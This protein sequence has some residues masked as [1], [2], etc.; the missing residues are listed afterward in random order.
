MKYAE[1]ADLYEELE[2]TSKNL[3]KT[4]LIAEFLKKVDEKNIKL[5]MLLLQG[6]VFPKHSEKEVGVANNLVVKLLK[7]VSGKEEKE[8]KKV[9]NETGDL[10]LTAGKV[11]E[12]KKQATLKT[13]ALNVEDVVESIRSCA[14]IT[15]S[16]AVSRKMGALSEVLSFAS[17]KEAKYFVRTILNTLRVGVAFGI[18][19]DAV[20][21]AFSVDKSLVQEKY[22]LTNDLGEIAF[23]LKKEGKKAL[24]KKGMSIGIPLRTML[25]H[26]ED[27]IQEGF[28]RVGRPAAIEFKYDGM[29]MQIHKEKEKV[30]I[31]TRRLD[32]VSNQFPEVVRAVAGNIK[33]DKC[34]LDAE[35]VAYNAETK[36]YLPFQQ[37]SR[38][39]KRKYGIEEIIK[40]IPVVVYVFD[41]LN[42]EGKNVMVLPFNER[43]ALLEK[44]VKPRK[45]V[46]DCA[47]QLVT[48][49]DKAAQSFYSKALELGEEGVM[50]KKVSAPYLPGRRVGYGVKIKPVMETLDLAITG[51]VWGE[52]KRGKWLSSFILSCRKGKELLALGKMGSGFTEEQFAELTERLKKIIVREDGRK[53]FV[54]PE[55]IVEVA[56]EEIQRSPTYNSGFALRF[57]RLVRVRD[58]LDKPDEFKKVTRIYSSQ[59]KTS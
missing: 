17:P 42:Y 7:N 12:K 13:K 48:S 55:V 3:E 21:Q 58:D 53:V 16:K 37:L 44:I 24:V 14:E 10:G 34:V 38:R 6:R 31:F 9:W 40:K 59:T 27:S 56:Y 15:G 19:R 28:E 49:A 33:A 11:L 45:W 25:Y 23:T 39:I 1:L 47:E 46:I 2:S 5:V 54:Q 29:R 41:I 36:N 26:K 30:V 51:A 43:R 52:G 50:M 20:S 4:R 22:D 35:A 57:P 32:N 18:L 8:I